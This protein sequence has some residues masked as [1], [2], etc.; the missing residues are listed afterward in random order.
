MYYE[1]N[2]I[3]VFTSLLF[4][5]NAISGLYNKK[6]FFAL[7][8]LILTIT[9][10]IV[11][12]NDNIYTNIIDKIVI[13]FVLIYGIYIIYT[14]FKKNIILAVFIL[15]SALFCGYIYIYGFFVKEFVFNEDLNI[16]RSYH[17]LMHL[18]CSISNH[19]IVFL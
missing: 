11:H 8:F 5:T 10:V 14:K 19:C 3:L 2:N 17:L 18:I 12:S 7:L 1:I 6:Y 16:S 15:L 4:L 9:S 13:I